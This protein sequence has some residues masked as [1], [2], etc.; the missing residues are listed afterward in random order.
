LI[1]ASA[2]GPVHAE[3][4]CLILG[5]GITG[6]G[7]ARDAAMRGLRTLLV[8]SNDF[9][10]G[11]SHLTSKVVHGGLR[12][13]EH[14]HFRLVLEGIVERDR[15]LNQV[16]P[17]LVRPLRFTIPFD[18]TRMPKWAA[19][20][21]GVQVY[22]LIEHLRA[23][24]RSLP[25]SASTLRRLYPDLSPHPFGVSFWD[26]Q[27]NDA[28]LVMA[29]LRTAAA[30]GA[31]LLNHTALSHAIFNKDGWTVGLDSQTRRRSWIV[32]AKTIVNATG[33]WS[34]TTSSILGA[35]PME[36]MWIKG[37]HLILARPPSFGADAIVIRSVRDRRPLWV[38][39]WEN[40]LIVGSTESRFTGDLRDVR[41]SKDEVD[42]LL[43]SFRQYF[44]GLS[45]TYDDIRCAYAGI[46]PIVHQHGGCENELSRRHKL[47]VDRERRLITINGGK[48]TTFRRMA[49]EAMDEL[50]RI[51]GWPPPA[52]D[53]RKRL[54]NNALWP[55]LTPA[56]AQQ[57]TADALGYYAELRGSPQR[58]ARLV[59][60]YGSDGVAIA[61]EAAV[62][63]RL[64]SPLCEDLPYSLAELGYLCRSEQVCHLLDL[65]KRRTSLYFLADDAAAAV[66][67][68]IVEHIR[69]LLG[70]DW[71]RG[72]D[73]MAAVVDE[74][75]ADCGAIPREQITYPRLA[76]ACA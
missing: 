48:L 59:R 31:G 36:L 24:R 5:G 51:A 71:Q 60:L 64:G 18:S 52:E 74:F 66:L 21:L 61:R 62:R 41:P 25:L 22:G 42:D 38:I 20:V 29:S 6:A 58:A 56:Q 28:R 45:A 46:R 63:P 54:R 72:Q 32:R 57:V 15:L 40:R 65:I 47:I 9:A 4:D 67:P 68:D 55:G 8:D 43:D 19:T 34:P 30:V 23:G 53:L 39:P 70:W 12:Y 33:P 44:P 17:H 50:G 11:T 27:T 73:E 69:L 26:A 37:S 2:I 16:A 1:R 49:E 76:A 35:D 13:L 14:G 75:R 10:S 3:V 7:V